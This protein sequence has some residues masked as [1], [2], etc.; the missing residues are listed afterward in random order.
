MAIV[1]FETGGMLKEV[2]IISTR[3]S[4][5]GGRLSRIEEPLLRTHRP[6][7]EVLEKKR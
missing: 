4:G 2:I 3:V 1:Q 7:A 6:R 5:M